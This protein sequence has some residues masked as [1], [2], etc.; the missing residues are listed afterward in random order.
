MPW[1]NVVSAAAQTYEA[2]TATFEGGYTDVNK[3]NAYTRFSVFPPHWVNFF[4]MKKLKIKGILG[5][6]P[7]KSCE[8]YM[9]KRR[10][11]L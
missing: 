3:G 6:C 4:T 7:G 5:I 10:V 11:W 9:D 2:E 1:V 8:D